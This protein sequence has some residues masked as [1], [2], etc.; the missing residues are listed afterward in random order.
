MISQ[1]VH[2]PDRPRA[3]RDTFAPLVHLGILAVASIAAVLVWTRDKEPLAASQGEVAV[4]PGRPADVERV[5]YESKT[6]TVRLDARTDGAGRYFL[7]TVEKESPAPYVHGDAGA[8]PPAPSARTTVAF[9]SV[10]AGAKLTEALGPLKALR[11]LGRIP[12][13]RATEFGLAE[14]EGT[15]VV[16]LAG[17]ER[18]LFI[19]GTTPGGGDRYV[20]EATSGEVYVLKG[21]PIRNL[22]GGDTFLIEHDL[23]EWKDAEVARARIDAGGK[24]REIVRGGPETKR[25][26]A[27]PSSPDTNDETLGNWMSKVEHVR[28]SEY[29]IDPPSTK[30]P[31]FRIE[32]SAGPK[33]LGFADLA[34]VPGPEKP[35]YLLRTERTRAF[36]KVTTTVGEQLEQDLA[37]LVK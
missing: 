4:W 1:P 13:N 30:T 27:N 8:Q 6:R 14:P 33:A 20:R 31:V 16:N 11:A 34:K 17:K 7:G 19:G 2:A 21:E 28:P 26:W 23:H 22:E 24:S 3:A 25:F 37:S 18:K 10:G 5:T 9:V 29:V 32:Y 36:C 15:I 12:D 35:T